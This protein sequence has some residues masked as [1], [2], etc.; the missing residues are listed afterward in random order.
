MSLSS[1]TK[2][3]PS[4]WLDSTSCQPTTF[5]WPTRMWTDV[6]MSLLD[7]HA[8]I[9]ALFNLQV[10]VIEGLKTGFRRRR[11]RLVGGSGIEKMR[12][13]TLNMTFNVTNY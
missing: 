3:E 7:F 12:V 11:R 4:P 1:P 10:L 9:E 8:L 6:D 2:G 13:T 5:L